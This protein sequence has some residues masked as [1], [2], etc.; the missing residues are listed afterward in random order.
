MS[1][2]NILSVIG[3]VFSVIMLVVFV[4]LICF[5]K[6]QE[7]IDAMTEEKDQKQMFKRGMARYTIKTRSPIKFETNEEST[8]ISEE[9]IQRIKVNEQL[10]E[11]LLNAKGKKTVLDL[12]QNK[13]N[14][15]NKRYL[16]IN[17]QIVYIKNFN[18]AKQS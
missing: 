14:I 5:F 18:K 8:Q 9:I 11:K 13:S 1:L 3:I 6:K 12:A 16:K 15:D 2:I 17:G 10:I 4:L 7:S